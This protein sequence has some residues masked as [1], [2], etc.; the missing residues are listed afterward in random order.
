MCNADRFLAAFNSIEKAMRQQLSVDKHISFSKLLDIAKKKNP[1]IHK[2][3][4]D[5]KENIQSCAMPSFMI[6]LSLFL[7][8]AEPHMQIV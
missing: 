8:I 4:I 6:G 1:I 7:I 5:L 3:E 2:Y